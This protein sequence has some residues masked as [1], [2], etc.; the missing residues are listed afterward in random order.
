MGINFQQ[1]EILWWL[2]FKTHNRVRKYGRRKFSSTAESR[3]IVGIFYRSMGWWIRAFDAMLSKSISKQ[4]S[5]ETCHSI[6]QT[7]SFSNLYCRQEEEERVLLM[8]WYTILNKLVSINTNSDSPINLSD[9][10]FIFVSCLW[11]LFKSCQ[12]ATKIMKIKR[13]ERVAWAM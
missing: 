4:H 6:C 5:G 10:E 12:Q 3:N 11:F 8:H 7:A 1:E 13:E 9:G 2:P